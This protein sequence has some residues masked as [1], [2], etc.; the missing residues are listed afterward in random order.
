M[1]TKTEQHLELAVAAVGRA[2]GVTRAVQQ[3]LAGLAAA[4]KDDKSPV[5]VAD[6]A[7]QAIIAHELAAIGDFAM[8]AEE[9]STLLREDD[10]L[11]AAVTGASWIF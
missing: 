1:T 7:A 8:V 5:T 11:L 6:F 3:N 2:C 4:S 9:S 10:A